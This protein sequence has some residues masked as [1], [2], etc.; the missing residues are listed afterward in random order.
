MKRRTFAAVF[1]SALLLSGCGAGKTEPIE[2]EWKLMQPGAI[3]LAD[4]TALDLWQQDFFFRNSY[5]LRDGT[6]ILNE[7]RPIGPENVYVGGRESLHDLPETAQ[8]AICAWYEDMGLLYDLESDAQ[9]AYNAY[10]ACQTSQ[11][12][13]SPRLVEQSTS[14]SASNG[15]VA[16]FLTSVTRPLEDQLGMSYQIGAAFDRATGTFI[17]MWDLFAV[18][19]AEVR[20][21]IAKAFWPEDGAE[22]RELEEKLLPEYLI[23]QPDS[24]NVQ[25]PQGVISTQEYA[26]IAGIDYGDLAGILHDWAVPDPMK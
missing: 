24:L 9:L 26:T 19:E 23:F 25:F 3:T 11:R 20:A 10:L 22:Q 7:E 17:P 1:L 13:F 18:S 15:Q 6:E 12:D 14:L 21:V 4:G 16:Y 2:A 8:T 5:R